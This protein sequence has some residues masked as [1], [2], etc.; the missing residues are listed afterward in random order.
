MEPGQ[1]RASSIGKEKR[2]SGTNGNAGY[3]ADPEEQGSAQILT[4]AAMPNQTLEEISSVYIGRYDAQVLKQIR[5][6]NPDLDDSVPLQ[7]G[8]LIRLPLPHGSFRKG[9]EMSSQPQ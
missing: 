3:S 7:A 9:Q 8:Q 2:L 5:A 6:L 4:V 1:A